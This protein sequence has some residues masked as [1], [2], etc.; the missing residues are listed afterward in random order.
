LTRVE[1]WNP[2][3]AGK[4]VEELASPPIFTLATS[5]SGGQSDFVGNILT[6]PGALIVTSDVNDF[7]PLSVSPADYSSL[8][9]PAHLE[10]F[11][12]VANDW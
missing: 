10:Q 11:W 4:T 6:S 3:E 9:D 8:V 1:S 12:R 5:T 2:L 7:A